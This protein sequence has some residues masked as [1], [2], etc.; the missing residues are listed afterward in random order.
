MWSAS[1]ASHGTVSQ[2]TDEAATLFFK[3]ELMLVETDIHED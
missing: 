3:A 2:E 1:V